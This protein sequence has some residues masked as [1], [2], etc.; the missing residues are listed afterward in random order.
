LTALTE[1][2]ADVVVAVVKLAVAV[3]VVPAIVAPP[4]IVHAYEVAPVTAAAVYV[5]AVA[6]LQT[7]AEPVI[8]VEAGNNLLTESARAVPDPH[9]EFA[10]TLTLPELKVVPID[11]VMEV[12]VL[13]VIVIPAGTVHVYDVA[14]VTAAM[15]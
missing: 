4:E 11:T 8:D 10:F 6:L 2:V 15:E 9:A 12:P 13:A 5:I 3:A 7:E 1:T 14:L